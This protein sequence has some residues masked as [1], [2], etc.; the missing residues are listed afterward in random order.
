MTLDDLLLQLGKEE[1]GLKRGRPPVEKWNPPLSGDIDI[2][3]KADGTWLHEGSPIVREKLMQL[4]ASILKKEG[5]EY[6]LVTP[7]EKWRIRVEDAPFVVQLISAEGSDQQQRLNVVTNVGDGFA[8][9]A[10][11]RLVMARGRQGEEVPYVE[12]RAG[13]YAKFSRNAYYQLA[14]LALAA[15]DEPGVWSDG[16]YF[17]LAAD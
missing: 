4:F 5:D 1:L 10:G 3:I 17:S 13:L 7:V 8:L 15:G 16:E 6:F 11:H 2:V 9:G 12:V 14:E